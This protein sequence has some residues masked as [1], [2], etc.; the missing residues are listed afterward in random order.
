MGAQG[1]EGGR[2]GGRMRERESKWGL[3]FMLQKAA[4]AGVVPGQKCKSGTSESL[5]WVTGTQL[6]ESSLL[7]HLSLQPSDSL[8]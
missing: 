8:N 2:E 1:G 3:L 4:T 5:M 6:L 7:I